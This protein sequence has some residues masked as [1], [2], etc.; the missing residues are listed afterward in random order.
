MTPYII[1]DFGVNPKIIS[2]PFS[3]FTCVIDLVIAKWVY[4][5]FL[6]KVTHKFTSV[7]L[8]KLDMTNFDVILSI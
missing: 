5:N 7:D 4:K 6:V 3:V 2:E 8:V 1:V